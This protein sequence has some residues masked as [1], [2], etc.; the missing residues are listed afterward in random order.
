MFCFQKSLSAGTF[1][2]FL[3]IQ[4]IGCTSTPI[5]LNPQLNIIE[6]NIGSG[7][8]VFLH[9]NDDRLEEEISEG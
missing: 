4:C 5:N 1:I 7:K 6:T 8:L 2:I 3:I 9:V